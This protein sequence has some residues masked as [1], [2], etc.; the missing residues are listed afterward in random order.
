MMRLIRELEAWPQRGIVGLTDAALPL[1][2]RRSVRPTAE[3]TISYFDPAR[4][5]RED[6]SLRSSDRGGGL[7]GKVIFAERYEPKTFP[8][9]PLSPHRRSEDSGFGGKVGIVG[10]VS[11]AFWRTE[12]IFTGAHRHVRAISVF[13]RVSPARYLCGIGATGDP[14]PR[15]G[16]FFISL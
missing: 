2:V 15:R 6:G 12:A 13:L 1:H 5:Y 4:L 10:N 16:S 8:T 9:I 7:P 3:R 11:V 14:L